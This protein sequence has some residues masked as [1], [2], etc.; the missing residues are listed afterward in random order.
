VGAHDSYGHISSISLFCLTLSHIDTVQVTWQLYSFIGGERT[1]YNPTTKCWGAIMDS[2]CHVRPSVSPSVRLHFRVR[3][4][5]PIP[6]EGFSSNLSQMFTS[7]RG[8]AESI[9]P[10]CQ[11]KVIIEGQISNDQILDSMS[12][13]LCN[14]C[15]SWKI[16][17]KL[18]SNVHLN[19]GMCRTHVA[20]VSAQGQGHNWRSNI[21]QSNIRQYVVS[22]L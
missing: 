15:T 7:R 5:N 21:K 8:C 18:G 16:F 17:F 3:S 20:H 1:Y 22:A 14:S 19:E 12:C 13:P 11:L 9:L 6:I 2:L 4:I 10:M